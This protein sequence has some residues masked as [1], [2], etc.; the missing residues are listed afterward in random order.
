MDVGNEGK[1]NVSVDH[2]HGLSDHGTV[3][4]RVQKF[5]CL[6]SPTVQTMAEAIPLIQ[7]ILQFACTD[8]F[9]RNWLS[10]YTLICFFVN[11]KLSSGFQL[12]GCH[13]FQKPTS[14]HILRMSSRHRLQRWW[15]TSVPTSGRTGRRK[16][17]ER[18]LCL[19]SSRCT[20]DAEL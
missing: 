11:V 10:N 4:F 12:Q 15:Q 6:S 5:H 13:F 3:P 7:N 18:S 17:R 20:G 9:S 16:H 2:C 8:L 19:S 1:S 14:S